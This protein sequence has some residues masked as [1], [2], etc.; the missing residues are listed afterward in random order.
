MWV[1]TV[2]N[3]DWP[4]RPG[5]P[6]DSARSELLA[7]LDRAVA[8]HL[9]VVLLQVRPAAD[10]LYASRLEPWS[11]YLT[12]RMGRAPDPSWDPLAFAVREAHRRGLELYAWLNPFRA[13]A[14]VHVGPASPDHVSRAHP[15]WVR[16]YGDQLWLDPGLPAVRAHTLRVILDVVRRY[17]VDGVE[18]DDYFYPYPVQDEGGRTMPFPDA[19]SYRLYRLTGGRLSR[20][21]WRRANVDGF[22]EAVD[23]AVHAVKPWVRFGVSPFGIWRPGHPAG[24]RGLDAYAALFADSRRWLRR[25]WVD[26]LAPQLYWP[27]GDPGHGFRRLARWWLEQDVRGRHV[28]LGLGAHRVGLGVDEPLAGGTGAD[29]SAPGP[30]GHDPRTFNGWPA[31][32]LLREVDIART[33]G[34]G[35][36]MLFSMSSLTDAHDSLATRMVRHVYAGP[37]LV[38]ATPWLSRGA[39]AAPRVA[40]DDTGVLE[41]RRG[42]R[43]KVWLWVVRARYGDAGWLTALVPGVDS[44][45]AVPR[46]QRRWADRVVVCAAD[47]LGNLSPAVTLRRVSGSTGPAGPG[48]Q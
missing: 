5:L 10:A 33:V 30:A 18:F 6:T 2:A 27:A 44:A 3:I 48:E 26:E 28:W 7:L 23:S 29:R 21:D 8:L 41:L 40:W 35:G 13:R 31:A 22:V 34:A 12:G 25:G 39:P 11:A 37:A 20:D 17:D 43:G 14:S 42:G 4:S 32:A 9:N 19:E 24:V 1:A 15:Q 36:E 16:R 46:R 47:R 38:P 45:Y